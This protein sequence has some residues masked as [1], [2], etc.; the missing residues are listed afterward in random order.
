M[1]QG[2][3]LNIT[4]NLTHVLGLAIVRGDF[5]HS[6]PSEADICEQYGVSRSATREAVKVLT[7]KGLIRS[8]PKQGIRI[9]EERHWNMFD[10]DV[11]KWTLVSKPTLDLLREFFEMRIVTDSQAASLAATHANTDNIS[12]LEAALQRVRDADAGLDDSL[13]ADIAFF[14]AIFEATHNR[15]FLQLI[16]FVSTALR[17]TQRYSNRLQG[18]KL[19]NLAFYEAIFHAIDKGNSLAAFSLVKNMLDDMMKAVLFE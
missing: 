2:S 16:D 14:T 18:I 12:K 1:Y 17:V 4:Q 15:F 3:A 5:K 8:R 19:I 10:A 6:L 7:T 13:E 11:L 9:Q